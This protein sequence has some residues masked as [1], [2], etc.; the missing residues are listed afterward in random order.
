MSGRPPGPY[1]HGLGHSYVIER[2]F[3]PTLQQPATFDNVPLDLLVRI[4]L[5]G[6]G[7]SLAAVALSL[8]DGIRVWRRHS[9]GAVAAL[10]LGAVAVLA[11]LAGKALFESVLEK[12]K[13]AILIGCIA[14]VI[15]AAVRNVRAPIPPTQEPVHGAASLRDQ[16]ATTWT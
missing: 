16:G 11:G 6:F 15:A 8:R 5:V 12:G 3:A 2:P 9:D 1:G 10:A 4:G 13:I 7:L 14:G